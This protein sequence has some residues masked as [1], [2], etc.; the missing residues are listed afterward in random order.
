MAI[1]FSKACLFDKFFCVL[2]YCFELKVLMFSGRLF[3][4]RLTS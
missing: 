1:A 2:A 3:F 4:V